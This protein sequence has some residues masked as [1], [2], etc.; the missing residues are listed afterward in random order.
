MPKS[1]GVNMCNIRKELLSPPTQKAQVV[2]IFYEGKTSLM[3]NFKKNRC[4]FICRLSEVMPYFYAP[5][6]D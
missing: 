6:L 3:A 4:S 1:I 5:F 2:W